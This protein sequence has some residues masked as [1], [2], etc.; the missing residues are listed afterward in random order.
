LNLYPG[1]E[2]VLE[3]NADLICSF[4]NGEGRNNLK[5]ES[6]N[7]ELIRKYSSILLANEDCFRSENK[8]PLLNTDKE[9]FMVNKFVNEEDTKTIYTF[10]NQSGDKVEGIYLPKA[11]GDCLYFDLWNNRPLN[12]VETEN[13]VYLD[14]TVLNN[15]TGAV[16]VIVK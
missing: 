9:G 11:E 2:D 5:N 13:G 4:F 7:N 10:L 3:S 8:T 12:P 15:N 16:A 14:V 6:D 1:G